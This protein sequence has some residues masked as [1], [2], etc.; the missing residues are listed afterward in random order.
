MIRK[1]FLRNKYFILILFVGFMPLFM[2]D[3][4]RYLLALFIPFA[5]LRWK[6]TTNGLLIAGFSISYTAAF[7]FRGESLSASAII[8]Y[9]IYPATLYITGYNLCRRFRN[10]Q[11]IVW[12]M[13]LMAFSI[14]LPAIYY[15]LLDFL[16]SGQLIRVG[17]DITYGEDGIKR[18]ATGYGMM[19]SLTLGLT[20]LL[21]CVCDNKSDFKRK[22]FSLIIAVT[23]IFCTVRLLNRTGLAIAAI[24][25]IAAILSLGIS[26]KR[27][28][29]I[30]SAVVLV[31]IGIYILNEHSPLLAD[32]IEN[33]SRRDFGT[34]SVEGFGGRDERW[35]AA[36]VQII[37]RPFGDTGLDLGGY[38]N[39][40][41]NLWLD[42]GIRGGLLSLILL[43]IITCKFIKRGIKVY[44]FGAV[45]KFE[46]QVLLLIGV[47]FM[48]QL[49]TEPIIE[50][51][52]QFFWLWLF[53]LGILDSFP[54]IYRNRQ[55]CSV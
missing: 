55:N 53:F 38:Y 4:C 50:G 40:A 24:S 21:F 48:L 8:Y 34:G 44:K 29:Y 3:Y 15:N 31:A 12:L 35:S 51:L 33:Y 43:L 36:L 37:E 13:V 32:A 18:A 23:A 2:G 30:L 25:C 14:A 42:T 27:L 45:S 6:G 17:R 5:F 54:C 11:S 39:Y 1:D 20:G 49:F 10:N 46:R 19:M 28:F 16:Q 52:P 9:L 41:H 47:A 7:V 22:V 26:V